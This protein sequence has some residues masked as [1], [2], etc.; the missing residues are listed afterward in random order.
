MAAYTDLK[1]WQL[2]MDLGETI[3]TLTARFPREEMYGLTQQMRRA[4]VSIPSNSAEG[5]GR[6]QK[7][8]IAQFLRVALGSAR[9]LETQIKLA[10]RLRFATAGDVEKARDECDQVGKM[11][12]SLLSTV[13]RDPSKA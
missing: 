9:E 3:Y 10:T 8:Y 5:Y 4:A 6:D 2:S 13:E 7:G 1:V 12:R 11:L